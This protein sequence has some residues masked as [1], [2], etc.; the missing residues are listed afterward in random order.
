MP[1]LPPPPP[2]GI[3]WIDLAEAARRAGYSSA[4][5][6]RRFH[7]QRFID[8][9]T[10]KMEKPFGG[11]K[12]RWLVREDADAAFARVKFPEQ[13]SVGQTFL[14]VIRQ[15]TDKQRSIVN[16]RLR[17][18]RRWETQRAA[19]VTLGLS[20]GKITAS[21]LD[22]LLIDEGKTLSRGTLYNWLRGYRKSGIA[23]LMDDRW[24]LAEVRSTAPDP[25]LEE[26][27]KHYL[28]L[29]RL[30]LTLCHEMACL[31]ADENGWE[32]RS[33]KTCQRFIDSI[34]RPVV[35]KM[36]FGE[37]A[38]N[39]EAQPHIECD[40][41]ALASNEVWCGDHHEFDVFVKTG[42]RLDSRTGEKIP[43]YARPWLT[44]WMDERSRKLVGY[45]IF[46]HDPN[47]DTILE[48]FF[49][50][51]GECGVP[52]KIRID[53]GKDYDSFALQGMTKKQRRRLR[54]QY[55]AEQLRGVF[56]QI[57]VKVAHVEIY[58]GQSKVIERFFGTL[59]DRFGR[60]WETYCGNKPEN[61][62]EDFQQKL[63][64]GLAP[65]LSDFIAAFE[66]WVK[67]D[68]HARGHSGDSMDGKSP[69]QVWNEC[70][71][72]KVTC[73]PALA[74]LLCLKPTPPVKVSQNGVMWSGLRYG[75]YEPELHRR[76]G[77]EVTLRINP[78][79]VTQISVWDT[80][81]KFV[82][83]APANE[84]IPKNADV[85]LVREAVKA[86]R[87]I[88]RTSDEYAAIR[89]HRHE[90]IPE[91]AR[92]AAMK[93]NAQ[94]G[95]DRVDHTLPPPSLR[96]LRT[97][98]SEQLKAYQT[99]LET[100]A[101]RSAVGGPEGPRLSLAG[102]VSEKLSNEQAGGD[103]PSLSIADYHSE[104]EDSHE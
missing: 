69:Q 80:D 60:T 82:C 78:R 8:A 74:E 87:R 21:F 92:R 103:R 16:E 47:Q 64:R 34:P 10:A 67:N 57:G 31:K 59:E 62:P 91:L 25:F 18:V 90:D 50:A 96:P 46:T 70:L 81:G 97:P 66:L 95:T 48:S 15:L 52:A 39:N 36:R 83:L 23:G 42:E 9:G 98:I 30:K 2:A 55:D 12:A 43:Q 13:L 45:T 20:E 73:D 41:S 29:R 44:A 94:A 27:K 93:R 28:T 88:A 5:V 65:T 53:N 11:G 17:L 61:R 85:Q 100:G 26:V 14:S 40:Y 35:L 37:E 56:G 76:I 75:K 102:Y 22:K 1:P 24:Q 84:K 3:G 49:I 32:K 68:Y 6:I 51:V 58:H 77:Q 54:V 19:G 79:D 86:K 33:Y 38:H 89:A 63:D 71:G 72:T 101:L 104:K 4:G 99:A 7:L